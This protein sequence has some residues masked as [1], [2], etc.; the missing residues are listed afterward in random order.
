MKLN[1]ELKKTLIVLSA[2]T[3]L[4]TGV[5]VSGGRLACPFRSQLPLDS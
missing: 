1:D 3:L 5:V 4:G 2:A